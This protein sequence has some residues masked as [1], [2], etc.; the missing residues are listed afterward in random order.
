M[1]DTATKAFTPKN[2]YISSL[3]GYLEGL[4][5]GVISYV[6]HVHNNWSGVVV[7]PSYEAAVDSGARVWWCYDVAPSVNFSIEEQWETL[8]RLAA[9][10]TQSPVVPGLS[11]DGLA[12]S[13]LNNPTGQLEQTKQM[14]RQKLPSIGL[15]IIF[16]HAPF[17][18]DMDMRAL[19]ENDLFISVTPESECHFGHGQ[20]I[21]RLICDQASLGLDTNW[22]YSGDMLTQARLWLQTV[23]NTIY[24]KTLNAGLL[25][26]ESPM[27]VEQAFLLATRQG[28]RT[29]RRRDIGVL[30]V[31]A[32][33]DIVVFDGNSPNMLGWNDSVDAV[34]LH[35]NTSDI[36]HVLVDE[37]FRKRNFKLTRVD[38]VLVN[39]LSDDQDMS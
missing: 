39:P 35:A 24:R 19:R 5:A 4:N 27:A 18:T 7:E 26:R 33:A 15:P 9:K 25:P 2:G 1:A 22:T 36:E 13:F 31:G 8:G 28:G 23:R 17:L 10:T 34:L 30:Q 29:L 16:S 6:E 20:T 12:P 32:K 21:G 11:L 14:V 38:W 37:R 3:E